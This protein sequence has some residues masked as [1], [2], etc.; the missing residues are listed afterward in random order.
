MTSPENKETKGWNIVG[1]QTWLQ[2]W[3]IV[4]DLQYCGDSVDF[5]MDVVRSRV[6]AGAVG[7]GWEGEICMRKGWAKP[8]VPIMAEGGGVHLALHLFRSPHFPCIPNTK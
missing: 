6:S 4:S 5:S 8:E 7:A 3:K 1:E 2:W